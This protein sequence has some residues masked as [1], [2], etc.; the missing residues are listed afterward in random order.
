[1]SFETSEKEFMITVCALPPLAPSLS[2]ARSIL[3][4]FNALRCG[5]ESQEME[6]VRRIT[7]G[8]HREPQ[9]SSTS[10]QLKVK[11][12]T[13]SYATHPNNIYWYNY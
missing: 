7:C 6:R 2:S 9:P 13:V 5:G 1:M 8:C 11:R 4:D 3:K 12:W 10:E